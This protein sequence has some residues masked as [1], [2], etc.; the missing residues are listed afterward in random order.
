MIKKFFADLPENLSEEFFETIALGKNFRLERIISNGHS[1]PDGF[2][3]DQDQ[4]EF[5]IIMKGKAELEFENSK[6]INLSPGDYLTIQAHTKHRVSKTSDS[7]ETI[8]L[9]IYYE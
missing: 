6:F 1:S 5:V 4:D 8:W 3:Y 2:W 7:E 9:T